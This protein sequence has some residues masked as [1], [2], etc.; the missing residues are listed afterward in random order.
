MRLLKILAI[1]VVI[2]I[3]L[4]TL[5]EGFSSFVLIG[6]AMLR[7]APIAERVHTEFDEEIGW[8]N[9]PDFVDADMYGIGVQLTTNSQRFRGSQEYEVDVP[10]G[11]IR[12]V[13]SGD[14]FTLGYSIGDEQTYCQQLAAIDT[15]I[16][17]VNLGQGGY[18]VDQA[19]LWYR[20]NEQTLNHDIHL[21]GFITEDFD[22]M[23]RDTFAGYAKP[24]LAIRDG[25]LVQQNYPL[26]SRTYL[27]P[28]LSTDLRE[29]RNLRAVDLLGGLRNRLWPG[30]R[31]DSGDERSPAL[32]SIVAMTF[33]E[34]E[35]NAH[36][37]RRL[38]VLVHLP[39][40]RDYTGRER[41]QRWV[42][43][44]QAKADEQGYLFV[45]VVREF[46]RVAA[47]EIR[48]LFTP[49]DGHYTAKGNR[50]VAEILYRELQ[51]HL[52]A[53]D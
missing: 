11:K 31:L 16:E 33:A 40:L 15:R 26:S 2:T 24:L 12:I 5:V 20:R 42:D 4:I 1:N 37:N 36:A 32:E 49:R 9:K 50:Y 22:R 28:W 43:F 47:D 6:R 53:V 29:L 52:D 46:Q 41:T 7:N 45:D 17:P 27:A 10:A 18:G 34:L 14:S 13:C 8:I 39:V 23:R 25:R 44:I 3:A 48:S 38:L 30:S 19:Y 51:Q 21:F 35:R